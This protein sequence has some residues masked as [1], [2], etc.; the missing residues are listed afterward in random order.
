MRGGEWVLDRLAR[1]YGPTTLYTL[2]DDGRPLT[3]AI[4]A[5]NVVTSPLQRFPGAA[6]RLR[7]WYLPIM[8]WAVERLRV[9]PCDLVIST[10]SAVMKSI[11]P[12]L[13]TPHVCYCHSP[14]RYVWDLTDAYATGRRGALRAW[15]L[16]RVRGRFKTW[17]RRTADRVTTFVANST[18][19]AERIRTAYERD[20]IVVHPPVRTRFFTLDHT[21]ERED[22]LLVVS[23]LEPYK[24]VDLVIEA[25]N[26]MN[27]PLEIAGV[28]SQDAELRAIA[29]PSV[30]FHGRVDDA[31]LLSLYQRAR[32]FVFPQ[33]E[34]F[35]ITA[36][37]AQACGCPVIAQR[38]GG[39][40]DSVT[41]ETGVFFDEGSVEGLCAA[42][43]EMQSR[44]FDAHACR[45]NAE[46]FGAE[47]FDA[48]MGAVVDGVLGG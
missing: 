44:A 43:E 3:A 20:A 5:C 21:I 32:A 24:R 34:D 42:V 48:R 23:A 27:V 19:T 31:A 17:D 28:G 13:G 4:G 37:E 22:F 15:G 45:V 39:A 47:V 10:S 9:Q 46:R 38:A 35:G 29:G 7:R 2:V 41:E 11:A 6:G 8:P 36:V 14:A 26:R 30:T 12:P 1:S 16:R 18:F 40:L 33:I 25:A